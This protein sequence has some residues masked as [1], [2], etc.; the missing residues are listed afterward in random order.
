MST[1]SAEQHVSL[2]TYPR[3]NGI[4]CRHRTSLCGFAMS[5]GIRSVTGRAYQFITSDREVDR[6]AS[7]LRFQS[8][9]ETDQRCLNFKL[10]DRVASNSSLSE[11][12]L[13]GVKPS[14]AANLR[15]VVK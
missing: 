13:D 12:E 9:E 14:P 4:P 3:R 10:R 11:S 1:P 15:P 7:S 8:V 2:K 5:A 6:A